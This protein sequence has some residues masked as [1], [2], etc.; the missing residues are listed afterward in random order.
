[1]HKQSPLGQLAA[2]PHLATSMEPFYL[3]TRFSNRY[4]CP[5]APV[6]IYKPDQATVAADCAEKIFVLIDKIVNKQL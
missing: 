5:T 2:L 6:D 4:P 3:E 1:M